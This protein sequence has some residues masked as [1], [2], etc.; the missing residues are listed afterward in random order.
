MDTIIQTAT[1]TFQ[2][3]TGIQLTDVIAFMKTQL[4]L[5]LGTGLG[6]LQA[7]MPYIL[8][9]VAIGAVVYFLYRAFAFFRH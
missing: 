6:V 8:A 9:L 5:V 7:L 1:S 4:M 2:T 3:A